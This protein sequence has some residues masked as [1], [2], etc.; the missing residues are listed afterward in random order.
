MAPCAD[1]L[2]A[3]LLQRCDTQFELLIKA[4]MKPTFA[5]LVVDIDVAALA[6]RVD[7]LRGAGYKATGAA[8]F[9]TARQLLET[10]LFDLLITDVR[11]MA[12]N[13]LHLVARSRILGRAPT[14]IVLGSFPD[15]VDETEARRL[16]ASYLAR[17]FDPN[18]LLAFVSKTLEG[19]AQAKRGQDWAKVA[20]L[21]CALLAIV[22]IVGAASPLLIAAI[23]AGAA[24]L[25]A[26]GSVRAASRDRRPGPRRGR[27]R[28]DVPL[29]RQDILDRDRPFGELRLMTSR[30]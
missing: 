16:G 1:S 17:P 11:L 29:Q 4:P 19:A 3:S 9:E 8:T 14:A 24:A 20:A 10:S 22:A 12:H 28:D 7:L 5:I 13:G 21:A 27:E 6:A 26:Y 15:V 23:T 30:P 25:S 2:L 18:T